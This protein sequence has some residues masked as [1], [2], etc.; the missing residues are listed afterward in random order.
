[1]TINLDVLFLAIIIPLKLLGLNHLRIV[2]QTPP[3]RSRRL[4]THRIRVPLF[5]VNL[6][7]PVPKPF[8]DH[9]TKMRQV[10]TNVSHILRHIMV[11]GHNVPDMK[12]L[13]EVG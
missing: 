8:V 13:N 6:I 11:I 9:D 4:I 10:S 7:V 3:P 1:M 5:I 12:V 2:H